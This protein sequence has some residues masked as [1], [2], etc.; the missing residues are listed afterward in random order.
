MPPLKPR[1]SLRLVEPVP[2]RGRALGAGAAEAA[3]EERFSS[4]PESVAVPS[5]DETPVAGFARGLRPRPAGPTTQPGP[6]ALSTLPDAQLVAI[7]LR[8]DS[9]AFEQLYRRHVTFAIHLATRI[10]GS[11]RD[12]EDIVHD[13]FLRAFERLPDL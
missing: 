1:R 5:A 10:E 8:G 9:A 12:V 6:A 2:R 3:E 13:A 4:P 7:G 11:A